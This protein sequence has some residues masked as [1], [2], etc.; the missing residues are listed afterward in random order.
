MNNSKSEIIYHIL[1]MINV[2]FIEEIIFR[3]FLF[4]MMAQ[5][6]IKNGY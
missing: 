1:T 6:N 5:E 3:G 4:K 2:G